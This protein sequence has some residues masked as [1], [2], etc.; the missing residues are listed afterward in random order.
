MRAKIACK[1]KEKVDGFYNVY[2][3]GRG[4]RLEWEV[5]RKAP[6]TS[7]SFY[8]GGDGKDD[9]NEDRKKQG[10][11]DKK[12]KEKEH[13]GDDSGDK[14]ED[15]SEDAAN[16]SFNSYHPTQRNYEEGDRKKQCDV[17]YQPACDIKLL[18]YR[19]ED[20]EDKSDTSNVNC[21]PQD[22]KVDIPDVLSEEEEIPGVDAFPVV[23]GNKE[24]DGKTEWCIV[25]HGSK[26]RSVKEGEVKEPAIALRQSNRLLKNKDGLPVQTRAEQ[27]AHKK[28]DISGT[29]NSFH[30]FNS[31]P[32]AVLEKIAIDSGVILGDSEKEINQQVNIFK[33]KE[34]AEA[35]LAAA[36]AKLKAEEAEKSK[37]CLEE[38]ILPGDCPDNMKNDGENVGHGD[39][40]REKEEQSSSAM[41]NQKTGEE[42]TS[43]L[44]G[45]EECEPSSPL[46]M[47]ERELDL[48]FNLGEKSSR[49]NVKDR[50]S[51]GGS[52]TKSKSK[53]KQGRAPG[54]KKRK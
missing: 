20:A 54:R 44:G 28:N 6:S 22:E 10:E 47:M 21:T 7:S 49:M 25:S 45:L 17:V 51:R 39:G 3:N 30:V 41:L 19:D 12:G 5:E 11:K 34:L 32:N 50:N 2:I 18:T 24:W 31:Y 8:P 9:K 35:V 53:K 38:Q 43:V 26:K 52:G 13:Q 48:E 14:Q 42:N 33:A 15:A 46:H 16:G 40:S 37:A 36:R 1:D 29:I 23:K 27:R 4:F